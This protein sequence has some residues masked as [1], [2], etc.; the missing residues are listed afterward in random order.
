MGYHGKEE[1]LQILLHEIYKAVNGNNLERVE[2]LSRAYQ[3]IQ[4]TA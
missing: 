3:R 2:V 4:A 1:V